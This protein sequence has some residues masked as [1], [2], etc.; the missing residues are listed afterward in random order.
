MQQAEATKARKSNIFTWLGFMPA[1]DLLDTHLVSE[2][3]YTS[4]ISYYIENESV[5][6]F[7]DENGEVKN[8]IELDAKEHTQIKEA[9]AKDIEGSDLG[10]ARLRAQVAK[11]IRDFDVPGDYRE[12]QRRQRRSINND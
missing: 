8:F 10:N 4:M 9:M 2:K 6:A 11:V 7:L 3:V 12:F 5:F 1:D